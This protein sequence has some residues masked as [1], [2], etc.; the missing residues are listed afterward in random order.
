LAYCLDMQTQQVRVR[1]NQDNTGYLRKLA[2]DS[3]LQQIEIATMLLHAALSAMRDAAEVRFP[4]RFEVV[5]KPAM[6][7]SKPRR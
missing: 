7:V 4:V 2:D 6:P 3:G 1:L 5:T